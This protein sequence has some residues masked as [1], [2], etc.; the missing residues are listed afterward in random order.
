MYNSVK[1]SDFV[2]KTTDSCYILQN[3]QKTP[4]EIEEAKY[5]ELTEDDKIAEWENQ[6]FVLG[7]PKNVEISDKNLNRVQVIGENLYYLKGY[8]NYIKAFKFD[9]NTFESQNI[10]QEKLENAK[11]VGYYAVVDQIDGMEKL[12]DDTVGGEELENV[13]C[14]DGYIFVSVTNKDGNLDIYQ[15][16]LK[17][18]EFR[19]RATLKDKGL[20]EA[21]KVDSLNKIM[22]DLDNTRR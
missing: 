7:T 8:D 13:I 6:N 17:N 19:H 2:I 18:K 3:V 15:Y 10:A 21:Y 9:Q 14:T 16:M 1:Y 11:S 5:S 22:G 20:L 4:F 12:I